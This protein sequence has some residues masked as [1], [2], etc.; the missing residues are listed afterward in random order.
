MINI[1]GAEGKISNI[2]LFLEKV[3]NFSKEKNIIV[4]SFDAEYIYDKN[5]L[6]SAYKHAKRAFENKT[7]T[8]NTLDMEILLYA[9]GERQLKIAIPKM[10]VKK[11]D[12]SIVF[13]IEGGTENN[14]EKIID[15]FLKKLDLKRN[16][17]LLKGDINTLKNLGFKDSEIKTVSKDKYSDLVLEKVAMVDIIK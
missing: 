15:I 3:N 13:V 12:S 9:S 17:N 5:H 7:N 4:Q 8:C 6:L 10:G 11:G 2:D 16:D 14:L 1:F